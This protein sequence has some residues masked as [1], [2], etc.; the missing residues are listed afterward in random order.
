[1]KLNSILAG[2]ILA[3][4]AA[5][6]SMAAS[7]P[8]TGDKAPDFQ[9][10]SIEGKTVKFSEWSAGSPAVLVVLRGWPGYQCPICTKQVHEFV[11]AAPQS[12]E[13]GARVV[14]VYLGPAED[15]KAHADEFIKDKSWPKEFVFLLDPDYSMVNAYG[16]RWNEA[17]ETA[18]PS[19]FVLDKGGVIRFAKISHEH[20]GRASHEEVLKALDAAAK[21]AN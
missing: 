14:M 17:R 15:L 20:A 9:L 16:L 18:Y 3:C 2:A 21:Q 12:L 1:M 8:K 7:P 4:G 10:S 11:V 19:T 5:L 13:K 6:A